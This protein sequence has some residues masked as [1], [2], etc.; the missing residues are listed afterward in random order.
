MIRNHASGNVLYSSGS[1][2][3]IPSFGVDN[4]PKYA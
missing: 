4:A 3:R 1:G 2:V